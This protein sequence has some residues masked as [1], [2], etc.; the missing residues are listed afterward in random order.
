MNEP[1]PSIIV[2]TDGTE[3]SAPFVR[4]AA[5][6][7]KAD[8]LRLIAYDAASSGAFSSPRPNIWAAGGEADLYDHPLD[9]V[10]L[11]KLGQHGLALQVQHARKAGTD[12]YGWL[13]EQSSG[14]ALVEYAAREHAQLI[15]L[16]ADLDPDFVDD[17]NAAKGDTGDVQV[18]MVP[19]A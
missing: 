5:E 16:P 8:G 9:P 13:P 18:E 7:A 6:R 2:C 12:A 11:E 10:E 14:K 1:T 3:R 17:V 4:A 15:L 19:A